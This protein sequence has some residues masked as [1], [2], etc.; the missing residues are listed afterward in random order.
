MGKNTEVFSKLKK[1]HF[2]VSVAGW[3]LYFQKF[4]FSAVG[5]VHTAWKTCIIWKTTI[6]LR[7]ILT[8]HEKSGDAM[9]APLVLNGA[10][11]TYVSCLFSH[12]MWS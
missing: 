8:F 12:Q 5:Y 10:H 3:P 9:F 1:F 4:G 11:C 6:E 2:C 7:K